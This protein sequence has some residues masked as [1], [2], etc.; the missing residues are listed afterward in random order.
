MSMGYSPSSPG[1]S[2]HRVAHMSRAAVSLRDVEH[3]EV[4]EVPLDFGAFDDIEAH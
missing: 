4:I 1:W 2:T 3:L